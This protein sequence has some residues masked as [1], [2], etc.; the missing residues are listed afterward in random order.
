MILLSELANITHAL[1][2]RSDYGYSHNTFIASNINSNKS[3]TGQAKALAYPV[4]LYYGYRY[5][6]YNNNNFDETTHG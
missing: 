4:K 3:L 1:F 2:H 5:Y 6:G